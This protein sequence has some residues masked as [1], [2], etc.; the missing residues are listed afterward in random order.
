M[1]ILLQDGHT[2]ILLQLG[3][4]QNL[5]CF[6]AEWTTKLTMTWIG[7]VKKF[8]MLLNGMHCEIYYD[9]ESNLKFT[10]IWICLKKKIT[11]SRAPYL[12]E[13]DTQSRRSLGWSSK[14]SS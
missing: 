13:W 9:M 5:L 7:E 8:T 4:M 10:I 1:Q 12:R 2:G 14:T 6:R 11:S 3:H